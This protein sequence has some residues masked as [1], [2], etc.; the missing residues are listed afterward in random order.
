[1]HTLFSYHQALVS[2]INQARNYQSLSDISMAPAGYGVDQIDVSREQDSH[3][4]HNDIEKRSPF[5]SLFIY[6]MKQS[7]VATLIIMMVVL[8]VIIIFYI[9]WLSGLPYRL[10]RDQ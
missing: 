9:K 4:P 7:Y 2:D 8:V 5:V 6:I 10:N 1:M 3:V